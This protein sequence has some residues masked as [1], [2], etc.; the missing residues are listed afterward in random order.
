MEPLKINVRMSTMNFKPGILKQKNI[1]R[2]TKTQPR[3]K[4]GK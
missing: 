2:K 1:N 3:R 4:K